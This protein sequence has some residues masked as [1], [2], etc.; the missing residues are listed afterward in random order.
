M[1][2][3]INLQTLNKAVIDYLNNKWFSFIPPGCN[4]VVP[5]LLKADE[6]L[7]MSFK[8]IWGIGM[9][10]CCLLLINGHLICDQVPSFKLNIN[11]LEEVADATAMW[12]DNFSLNHNDF[13]VEMEGD[14]N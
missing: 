11:E 9:T 7:S 12:R 2:A 14:C 6:V 4:E 8:A 5:V 1:T 13:V 10:D 3:I